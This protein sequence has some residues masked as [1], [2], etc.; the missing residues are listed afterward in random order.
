MATLLSFLTPTTMKTE[1]NYITP[2]RTRIGHVHLKVSDL[3]RALEFDRDLLGFDV[4][5]MYRDR[6]RE[7]WTHAEDGSLKMVTRPLNLE[8]LLQELG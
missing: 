2:D 7:E 8:D 1:T 5:T 6:P 3:E 4:T